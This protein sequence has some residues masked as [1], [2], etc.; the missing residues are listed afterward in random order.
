LSDECIFC[1]IVAGELSSRKVYDSERVCAFHD[2]HPQAPVHILIV[3][4]EHISGVSDLKTEHAGLVGEMLLAARDIAQQQGIGD[5][6]RLVINNG[7][8]A[9][10][11]V[12]HLHMHLLGG[13]PMRWPPG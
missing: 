2:M 12:F 9:G 3:P 6:Y 11:S 7:R 10:Q 1:K 5:G 4:R 8:K 13:R